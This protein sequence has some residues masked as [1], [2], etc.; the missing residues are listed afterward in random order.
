MSP[1]TERP[2]I[3]IVDDDED[4][5]A[6]LSTVLKDNGYHPICATSGDDALELAREHRPDL[7]CLDISMPPPT[8]VRVY[9]E[10]RGDPELKAIPVIMVTGVER[11]FE[12]FIKT[13]R[14]V[15]PPDGYH[16][17]PFDVDEL[18]ATVREIL[19]RSEGGIH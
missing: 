6:Y 11:E 1:A 19:G 15:P 12:E 2:C 8:G 7:I 18:L 13:R 10:L 3:L 4:V 14:Q 16:R 5:V 9:R 17:K